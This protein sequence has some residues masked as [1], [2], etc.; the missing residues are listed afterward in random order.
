M[1][2]LANGTKQPASALGELLKETFVFD[3]LP[4]INDCS[5]V[6]IVIAGAEQVRSKTKELVCDI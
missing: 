6:D 3:V 4:F 5:N 1:S 2:S